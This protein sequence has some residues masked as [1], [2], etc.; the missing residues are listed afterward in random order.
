[1]VDLCL[2]SESRGILFSLGN[3]EGLLRRGGSKGCRFKNSREGEKRI[4]YRNIERW[5]GHFI[6]DISEVVIMNQ[7]ACYVLFF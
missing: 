5:L 7:S 3:G 1:M 4:D 2:G 6:E